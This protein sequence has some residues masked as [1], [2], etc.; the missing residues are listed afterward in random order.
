[1][2]TVGKF[3]SDVEY[4]QSLST[5][6]NSTQETN[7]TINFLKDNVLPLTLGK[8]ILDIG[9]G[10][11]EVSRSLYNS[12]DLIHQVDPSLN[13][14]NSVDSKQFAN[15]NIQKFN[16]KIE[17]FHFPNKFYDLIVN[18]HTLYYVK[19]EKWNYIIKKSIAALKSNGY[20]IIV[21]ND[22][23]GRA[24]L[25]REFGSKKI[26][27]IEQLIEECCLL[28]DASLKIFPFYETFKSHSLED[29]LDVIAIYFNDIC[30]SAD[31]TIVT[32]YINKHFFNTSTN[33]Y[34]IN[35]IQYFFLLKKE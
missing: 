3:N 10:T 31:K 33:N 25:S 17:D 26:V 28:H 23:L 22:G 9:I 13:A 14:L 21:L 20:L 24:R 6:I 18:S 5:L 30:I 34:E 27:N 7:H 29:V 16:I 19:R 12:F 35:F 32:K 11:G 4:L 15:K 1:M 2:D 8:N